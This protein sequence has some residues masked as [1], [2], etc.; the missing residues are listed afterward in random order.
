MIFTLTCFYLYHNIRET[1]KR[2]QVFNPYQLWKP[3]DREL[4]WFYENQ[5]RNSSCCICII[6]KSK[7]AI[8]WLWKIPLQVVDVDCCHCG[9]CGGSSCGYGS[10]GCGY[11]CCCGSGSYDGGLKI[12]LGLG[13]DSYSRGCGSYG[14][15]ACGGCCGCGGRRCTTRYE[16]CGMTDGSVDFGYGS[17][18]CCC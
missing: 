4:R 8:Y 10:C 16:G 5:W 9:C 3:I 1:L 2:W 12:K 18:K 11:G 7:L 17:S 15:G 14:C 13:S 6:I